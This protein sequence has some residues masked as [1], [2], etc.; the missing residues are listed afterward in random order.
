MG[1]GGRQKPFSKRNGRENWQADRMST[2]TKR[3]TKAVKGTGAVQLWV[4][5]DQ[6][7]A[8]HKHLKKTAPEY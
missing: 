7:L 6:R 5:L 8:F 4:A 1:T 2:D 3:V